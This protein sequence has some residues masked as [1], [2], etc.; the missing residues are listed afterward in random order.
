[1][2]GQTGVLQK[3]RPQAIRMALN[4]RILQV[5]LGCCSLQLSATVKQKTD[6]RMYLEVFFSG[7]QHNMS[8]HELE[9]SF[10]QQL[11]ASLARLNSEE[12]GNSQN[13]SIPHWND[14]ENTVGR[15]QALELAQFLNA[16][17]G[18]DPQ[19]GTVS[20]Q[21]AQRFMDKVFPQFGEE[22]I[23][24]EDFRQFLSETNAGQKEELLRLAIQ[25]A[26][27]SDHP[28]HPGQ[29]ES[30]WRSLAP[31][32]KMEAEQLSIFLNF[33]FEQ[34]PFS[35][36]SAQNFIRIIADGAVSIDWEQF[37]KGFLRQPPS[38]RKEIVEQALG[39]A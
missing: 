10:A 3:S 19:S 26:Q 35:K 12:P 6:Y 17:K 20:E 13:S 28:L 37:N 36:T 5:F 32:G 1:M 27:Q 15:M 18:E 38:A 25:E 14:F 7:Q 9:A 21:A 11:E 39:V 22:G 31:G 2:H 16:L 30:T 23:G 8:G 24:L 4:H 29:I 34:D 33:G